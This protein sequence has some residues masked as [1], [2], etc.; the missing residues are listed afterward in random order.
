MSAPPPPPTTTCWDGKRVLLI[1]HRPTA[2]MQQLA[3]TLVE[4]GAHVTIACRH[5]Q[6][7]RY[8]VKK[9]LTQQHNRDTSLLASA[10]SPLNMASLA[11]VQDFAATLDSSAEALDLLVV[12]TCDLYAAGMKDRRWY[13]KQ[14]VA[15]TA[16][17]RG[18]VV[19]LDPSPVL[20]LWRCEHAW[21]LAFVH[22]YLN[23][24][25]CVVTMT[26][27]NALMLLLQ[28]GF[29]GRAVLLH[30][31]QRKLADSGTAVLLTASATHRLAALDDLHTILTS[32]GRS[33][34]AATQVM[35]LHILR[36]ATSV[37]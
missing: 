22:M 37:G 35:Q 18:F 26:P 32:W 7:A 21:A 9:I 31:L 19:V 3:A 12:D 4:A 5:R 8:A 34:L 2:L 1:S 25:P 23:N 6:D 24:T 33:T 16:Q 17:V 27:D 15:G 13:T 30:L 20:T 14:G 11:S 10:S 28:T 36:P 29:V